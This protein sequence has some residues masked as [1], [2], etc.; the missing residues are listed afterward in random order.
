MCPP[1]VRAVS[2]TTLHCHFFLCLWCL[3]MNRCSYF[4]VIKLI[5]IWFYGELSVFVYLLEVMVLGH[6]GTFHRCLK[7]QLSRLPV[8]A[9]RSPCEFCLLRFPAGR[10]CWVKEDPFYRCF[11][12]AFLKS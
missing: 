1:L 9:A 6:E 5:D 10:R 7:N 8:C 4:N 11:S 2:L 3:L 12:T